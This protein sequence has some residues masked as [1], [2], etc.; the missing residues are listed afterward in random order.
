MSDDP[1]VEEIRAIRQR[2]AARLNFDIRAIVEDAMAR[3]GKDGREVVTRPR[4]RR[5][6]AR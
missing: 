3:Q 6:P 2:Q 1:I 5:A 4:K